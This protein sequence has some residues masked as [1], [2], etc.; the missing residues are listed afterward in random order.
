MDETTRLHYLEVM[1]IESWHSKTSLMTE[2]SP[3]QTSP[4]TKTKPKETL[5]TKTKKPLENP[6][7]NDNWEQLLQAVSCCQKCELCKTRTQ[8]VFGAGN[9]N[10]DWFF[11][12]EAPGENEDLQGQPFVGNAGLLLTEMIR[13]LGLKRENVFIANILKCRPPNNRDPSVDEIT[14]CHD[15]LKRQQ[16]LIKPKIIIAVGRIAAQKLLKTTQPLKELRGVVHTIDNIPLIVVYH[17]AYLLR[18]LTQKRAA[19]Q[20]LQ[21]ALKTYQQL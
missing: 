19:W 16:A 10:A 9:P 7:I 8:P 17:P 21:L 1:G 18:S 20:D 13:A 12:G 3:V 15:Y 4:I 5:P 6:Q 14:A 2:S 11:I